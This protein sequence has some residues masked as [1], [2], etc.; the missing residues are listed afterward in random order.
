MIRNIRPESQSEQHIKLFKHLL[1][2]AVAR[3]TAL[4]DQE[5][6]DRIMAELPPVE[7]KG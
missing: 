3:L 6:V 5:A 4:G 7:R 2:F 1:V